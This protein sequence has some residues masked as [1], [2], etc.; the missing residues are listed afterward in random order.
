MLLLGR[1]S[2]RWQERGVVVIVMAGRVN[3]N[4]VCCLVGR[5]FGIAI[6]SHGYLITDANE[7]FLVKPTCCEFVLARF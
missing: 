7:R 1:R 4:G 3:G 5:A 2:A 6:T